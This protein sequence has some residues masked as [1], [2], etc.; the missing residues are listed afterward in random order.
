MGRVFWGDCRN[1]GSQWEKSSS[2]YYSGWWFSVQL[3]LQCV[4]FG[5]IL[6]TI[7]SVVGI[8]RI[9][10]P[11]HW[12]LNLGGG[13]SNIFYFHWS[14]G[15][16]CSNLA[17][18]YFSV[19]FINLHGFHY[20]GMNDLGGGWESHSSIFK[21][22]KDHFSKDQNT[23]SKNLWNHPITSLKLIVFHWKSMVGRRNFEA[24]PIFRGLRC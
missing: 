8:W 18:A 4:V 7:F 21:S 6:K 2:R 22:F 23:H 3:F 20:V 16:S 13:F 5:I 10:I 9:R 11:T 19:T 12:I 24:R 1:L 14:L 17:C 15:K